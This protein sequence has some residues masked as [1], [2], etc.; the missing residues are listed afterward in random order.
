MQQLSFIESIQTKIVLKIKSPEFPIELIWPLYTFD[1]FSTSENA[2]P[3]LEFYSLSFFN[4]SHS[5]VAR[6]K[7]EL[8][9]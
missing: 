3:A 5:S 1:L 2:H 8:F 6:G 7:V 9:C 4:D